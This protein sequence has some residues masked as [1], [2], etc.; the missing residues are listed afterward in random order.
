MIPQKD[1][2]EATLDIWE[3]GEFIATIKVSEKEASLYVV[4]K[5]FYLIWY[6]GASIDKVEQITKS[7][8]FALF[9]KLSV[10]PQLQVVK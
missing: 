5:K 1:K 8:A 6:D 10:K 2:L 4:Q 7:T 9:P 3:K